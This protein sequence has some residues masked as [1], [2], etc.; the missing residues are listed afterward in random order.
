MEGTENHCFPP[1]G[2]LSQVVA[3]GVNVLPKASTTVQLTAP[4][5]PD[6]ML[7]VRKVNVTGVPIVAE[8]VLPEIVAPETVI[9]GLA[10]PKL[11][12]IVRSGSV[13][14]LE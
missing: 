9:T 7:D 6:P 5:V 12:L 2:G 8:T 11:F 1:G 3:I 4:V 13:I 14:G 10:L